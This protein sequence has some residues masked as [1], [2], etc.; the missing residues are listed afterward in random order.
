MTDSARERH[1]GAP[2]DGAQVLLLTSDPFAA[3]DLAAAL[4]AAG[5]E[6][7]IPFET[8]TR[9]Q[10][11]A[12]NL[13]MVEPQYRAGDPAVESLLEAARGRGVPTLELP[14]DADPEDVLAFAVASIRV[15]PAASEGDATPAPQAPHVVAAPE[16]AQAPHSPEGPG[17]PG[18]LEGPEKAEHHPRADEPAAQVIP[19]P[20]VE[21]AP[22]PET[23]PA[24]EAVE[25]D[26]ELDEEPAFN[27]ASFVRRVMTTLVVVAVLVLIYRGA[28]LLTDRSETPLPAVET[29]NQ[30]GAGGQTAGTAELAGR[31]TRS[32]TQGSVG[33]AT[34]VANGPSGPMATV[35]DSQGRWRFTELRGGTYVV[36]STVPRFVAKQVQVDVPEGR[37]VENVHLSLDPEGP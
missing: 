18:E 11:E 16:D 6:L 14:E 24:V 9:Q 4:E 31:I 34:V 13:L 10:V 21:P 17:E 3:E 5:A 23:E 32:D 15:A 35:T 2:L 30:P 22:E 20:A 19:E 37:T 25:P 8:P 1:A 36:M 28:G 33:G 12:S 27:A 26:A 7:R 29:Q